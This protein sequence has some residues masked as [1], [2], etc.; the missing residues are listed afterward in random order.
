MFIR[1]V[2]Q[3]GTSQSSSAAIHYGGARR[4]CVPA[5]P[6]G[7]CVRRPVGLGVCEGAERAVCLGDVRDV[8]NFVVGVG[9][10]IDQR[11]E[12]V[13][14]ALGVKIVGRDFE[15]SFLKPVSAPLRVT[16]TP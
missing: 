4:S 11:E 2:A 16:G 15:R 8:L 12:P 1:F 10:H 3:L 7:A 5:L 14:N 6:V 9:I 13:M